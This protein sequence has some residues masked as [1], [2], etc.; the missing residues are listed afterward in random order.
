MVLVFETYIFN[1]E[2]FKRVAF[3]VNN[4]TWLEMNRDRIVLFSFDFSRD[5]MIIFDFRVS[6]F[7]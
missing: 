1:F 5:K 7:D 6:G 4:Y 2:V 3:I